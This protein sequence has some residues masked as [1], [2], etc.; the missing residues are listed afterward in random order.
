MFITGLGTAPPSQRYAQRG[1]W[2]ELQ[3][4]QEFPQLKLR[5]RIILQKV[6]C[7]DRREPNRTYQNHD[8]TMR[9]GQG[10]SASKAAALLPKCN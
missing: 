6:L 3:D 9:I 4:W 7:R 8:F 1:I 2:N 10:A 5:S